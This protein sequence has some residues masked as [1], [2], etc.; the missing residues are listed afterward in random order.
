MSYSVKICMSSGCPV[1]MPDCPHY[2]NI[3]VRMRAT[4]SDVWYIESVSQERGLDV[5]TIGLCDKHI[6]HEQLVESI[7]QI[8]NTCTQ[9]RANNRKVCGPSCMYVTLCSCEKFCNFPQGKKDVVKRYDSCIW[10]TETHIHESS[11]ANIILHNK[12]MKYYNSK[13]KE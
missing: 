7:K 10:N 9:C 12:C 1:T 2:R 6:A 13:E 8:Q 3:P 5:F 11:L 4:P